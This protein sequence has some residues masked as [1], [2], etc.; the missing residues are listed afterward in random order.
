MLLQIEVTAVAA[1]PIRW[2]SSAEA[3]F[4]RIKLTIWSVTYRKFL[5]DFSG[6][7]IAGDIAVDIGPDTKLKSTFLP[8]F[9]RFR[10]GSSSAVMS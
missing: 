3:P 10:A 7:T 2:P 4:T 8:A 5:C 1:I 6:Y 9:D